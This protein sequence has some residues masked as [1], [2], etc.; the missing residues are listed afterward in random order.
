MQGADVVVIG[1][2]P[3]GSTTATLLARKGW[4][5]LLLERESFPREHVG[6][7]LLPA[8]MP[9]LEELGVLDAVAAEGFLP[10]WG[11]TM[12]WGHGTE[13]W[14]WH[15]RE[16]NRRHPHAY[17][18]WRPRFDQL[19][20]ENA[21]LHGVDVREGHRV[22]E[23][24]VESGRVQGVDVR[25]PDREEVR[26][27]APFVVDASGQAGLVARAFGHREPDPYFRNVAVYAYFANH[28]R[29]AEPDANNILVESYAHGWMWAIP[30][31]TGLVSVG[32]VVDATTAQRG[33]RD[34]GAD[35]F[36]A[37]Q[38]AAA[39]NVAR[40]LEGA[41]PARPAAVVR[42]W[43][44]RA[45]E[46]VGDGYV[47][48]GDAACFIDPLF[49]SGVHLA[50]T[51]GVHAAAYVT[52]VLRDPA[53]AP[54]TAP[55]YAELYEEHYGQFR[56]LA[57]LFYATNRSV[58]SYFWEARRITHASEGSAPREAFVRA[59]A[60]Q[61]PSG[62]ERAV[63]EAGTLPPEFAG[64][65]SALEEGRG[66]R[67]RWF[68]AQLEGRPESRRDLLA[69]SFCLAPGASLVRK[70]VLVDGAFEMGDVVTTAERPAGAPVS[71]LVAELLER[72]AG[73]R[74]LGDVLRSLV[75]GLDAAHRDAVLQA[76]LTALH[77]LY[78]DGA[79]LVAAP[80]GEDMG[81]EGT[82]HG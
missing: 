69:A 29:L 3:G 34:H 59:V 67:D 19:L 21:R 11:A 18:V 56:E 82:A 16:T 73:D 6:E 68:A 5:V 61:P 44:Y 75:A 25:T 58:D 45:R 46:V 24:I 9:I 38:V 35:A 64:A 77:I 80:V 37:E 51:A 8:T 76:A 2:G 79:V 65:L 14:S 10:K 17:Q 12:V 66:E 13:P 57:K 4:K 55:V 31:H 41:D 54:A 20:L 81:L 33:L 39:P 74:P 70:P 60:G 47:L 71:P 7:S 43:S 30:L 22:V 63:L 78:T 23:A 28:G 48:V 32:A 50:M 49:S 53:M 62:Y 42:D 27:D 52:T 36:L 1:G 26:I 72:L 40:L 15:F